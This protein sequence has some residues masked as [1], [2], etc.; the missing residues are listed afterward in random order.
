MWTKRAACILQQQNKTTTRDL[1][2]RL[3]VCGC[4]PWLLWKP[5]KFVHE[6]EP[7]ADNEGVFQCSKQTSASLLSAFVYGICFACK[8]KNH[9]CHTRRILIDKHK[10]VPLILYSE[11]KEAQGN[12]F[13]PVFSQK[14]TCASDRYL[15]H[16]KMVVHNIRCS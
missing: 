3:N 14:N 11:K 7:Y 8:K 12:Y 6:Q 9:L 2:T 16:H 1:I 15:K 5:R 13:I 10:R 4:H